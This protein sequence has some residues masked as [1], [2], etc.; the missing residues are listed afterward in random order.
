MVEA[1]GERNSWNVQLVKQIRIRGQH[2]EHIR[3]EC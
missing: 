1:M 2:V 3:L